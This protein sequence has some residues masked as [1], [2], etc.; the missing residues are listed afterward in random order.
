MTIGMVTTTEAAMIAVTGDWNCD[1]PVK[2]DSAAGTVRARSVEVSEAASRNS[3]QQKK[4]V[5]IAVVNDAGRGER[6]DHL[7]ERLPRRGA[8][9]LRRLLHLPRDLTE[10]RRHRPDRQRQREGQV[11]DDQP[12][13][14]VVDAQAPPHVEQRPDE[15]RLGE[16]RDRERHREQQLLAAEVQPCDR[17]G[18]E[19]RDDDRDERRDDRDAEGVAQRR[20][21]QLVAEHGAEVLQRPLRR[22]EASVAPSRKVAGLLNDSDTIHRSGNM[23]HTRISTP[24]KVHQLL[25]RLPLVISRHP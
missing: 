3:F 9:H 4:K 19:H 1:E 23:A 8:V 15:R 25:V 17:V 20:G 21:E 16:H 14:G 18:R 24:Q 7:A 11:R 13:P 6:H 5:R 12:D 22:E 2:N 10:E